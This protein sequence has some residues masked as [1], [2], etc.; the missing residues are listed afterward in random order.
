MCYLSSLFPLLLVIF[1]TVDW[2]VII[3]FDSMNWVKDNV[4]VSVIIPSVDD[5]T[6][7]HFLPNQ[8]KSKM[9]LIRVNHSNHR[10]LLGFSFSRPENHHS[11]IEP[12]KK[13]RWPCCATSQKFSPVFFFFFFPDVIWQPSEKSIVF[14]LN[15]EWSELMAESHEGKAAIDFGVSDREG[16]AGN[17]GG[18]QSSCSG[19]TGASETQNNQWGRWRKIHFLLLTHQRQQLMGHGHFYSFGIT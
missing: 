3:L 10:Q 9:Q 18:K 11:D 4:G 17:R 6:T 13:N 8:I 1:C 7:E 12:H 19:S 5:I 15:Q 16:E 2:L 14:S